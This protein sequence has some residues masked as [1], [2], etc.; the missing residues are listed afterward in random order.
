MLR[1]LVNDYFYIH[2]GIGLAGN[3]LFVIGSILFFK[4][5]E[6]W[7][8]V[9]VWMFVGGSSGMFLGSLGQLFKTIY[10]A[11]ERRRD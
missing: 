6:A 3:L 4:A 5:F 9:A 11:E 7:Y 2:L 8:T 1:T 10:E